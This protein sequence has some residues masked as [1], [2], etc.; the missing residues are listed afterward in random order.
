MKCKILCMTVVSL[1][2]FNCANYKLLKPVPPVVP[3]EG[4]LIELKKEKK[5]FE[6]K[7]GKKYFVIFPAPQ[8]NNFYLVLTMSD[9]D[10]YNSFL[11]ATLQKKKRYGDK[12]YDETM[13]KAKMSVF[14]VDKSKLQYYWLIDSVKQD[15]V[16]KLQYR[17]VPQWRFKYENKH[18][19]YKRILK[20]N[21]V[22]RATYKSIGVSY[23]FAGFNFTVAIDTISR[24]LAKIMEV[25][26]ELLAIESIFPPEILNSK[27]EAYQNYLVL[28]KDV[29]G[30]IQFQQDYLAALYFFNA[31][32]VTRGAV[33]RFLDSLDAFLTFFKYENRFPE[34]LLTE[35][36]NMTTRS[37][38]GVVPYYDKILADKKDIA[39]FDT[40]TY[41]IKELADVTMLYGVSGLKMPDDFRNLTAFVKGFDDRSA[42]GKAANEKR[43]E[44][45]GSVSQAAGM[46]ANTF[47]P[48]KVKEVAELQK[49]VPDKLGQEFGKYLTYP[50]TEKLNLEIGDLSGKIGRMAEQYALA[51]SLVPQLNALKDQRDFRSM[52]G[53]LKQNLQLDFLVEKYKELDKMSVDEQAKN[54]REALSGNNWPQ[55]ETR[56]KSLHT[57]DM[58]LNLPAILS[59]KKAVVGDLE[60][61]LYLKV[62]RFSRARIQKFLAERID[63]LTDIDSLYKDSVFVPA[64]NITFTTGTR[65]DLVQNK[66]NLIDH[67]LKIRDFE[68]PAQ[69][70]KHLYGQFVKDPN[71]NGVLK[72]RAIVS[73][74]EHYRGDDNQ[75]K[76]SAAECNPHASKWITKPTEYRKVY[77]LPVTDNKHGENRYFVRLNIRCPSEAKFPVYDVNVKLPKDL[78]Q[79]ASSEQW[80]E[81]LTIN[82]QPLKNE[83]RFTITAPTS[84]NG[85]ECQ[86]TPVQMNK[87]QNN[88]LDIYF[89][90]K[91]FRVF[92]M[93][94]M[95]Q[96]PIIKKN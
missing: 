65:A 4:A 61:S 12:I 34:P 37:L 23:H 7:K 82:N 59:V 89:K 51:L 8:A 87:D 10:K 31:E 53:I 17:Y 15:L 70:I 91:S 66:Q 9:K 18:A 92:I 95:V 48:E 94:V 21:R 16:V 26:K 74:S 41:R 19:E 46:P 79:N 30:E 55:T 72:A 35:A 58:Y 60:D 52:I 84:A 85:Y 96:K 63:T 43:K 73:H 5:D 25:E 29:E 32:Y 83:G 39:P 33:E 44:I 75:I 49:A 27:D 90:S 13:D 62:D 76:M 88:F 50:C 22:E 38:E 36:K 45:A 80:Y 93:S 56:L 28:K 3:Q 69:A 40:Q 64:Y 78:A 11:T 71:D 81:K 77:A 14:P 68:F 6:L 2:L 42:A 20:E 24:K 1:F 47:F 54:I 57:D 67:L 86:I